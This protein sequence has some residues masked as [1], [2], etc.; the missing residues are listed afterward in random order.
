MKPNLDPLRDI[1]EV[2]FQREIA[3]IGPI[4]AEE[5]RL[6]E[7]LARLERQKT[8][9]R[10]AFQKGH[11]SQYLGADLMWELWVLRA[12]KDLNIELA[13]VLARKARHMDA[14]RQAFGRKQAL[15]E[16]SARDKAELKD[17]RTKA[18]LRALREAGMLS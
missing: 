8:S 14:V 3:Q 9:A 16:I 10:E 15:D 17:K 1:A 18:Y 5:S 2:R 13:R 6:R 12:Q 4:L 11:E 7:A